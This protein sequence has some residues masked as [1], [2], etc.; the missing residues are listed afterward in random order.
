MGKKK[1]K[2]KDTD[3]YNL[4]LHDSILLDAINIFRVPGGW[5]Y[6]SYGKNDERAAIFVPFNDEFKPKKYI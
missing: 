6:E 1:E 2:Q 5:I 4:G 3:I